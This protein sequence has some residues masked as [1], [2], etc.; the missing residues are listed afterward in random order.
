MF[1]YRDHESGVQQESLRTKELQHYDHRLHGVLLVFSG[2]RY[3]EAADLLGHSPRM[4][5]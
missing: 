5:D 1:W 4:I 3:Y 2:R